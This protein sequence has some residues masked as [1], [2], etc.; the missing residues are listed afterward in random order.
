MALPYNSW[1]NEPNIRKIGSDISRLSNEPIVHAD[2]D[3]SVDG[4]ENYFFAHFVCP[5][6]LVAILTYVSV[7]HFLCLSLAWLPLS[8]EPGLNLTT[9]KF[10]D[11]TI[12][13]GPGCT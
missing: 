12:F 4:D 13:L 7:L 2:V 1:Y 10:F 3:V 9:Y 8:N 6:S 11:W 5:K